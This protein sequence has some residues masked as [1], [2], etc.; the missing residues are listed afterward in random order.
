MNPA[1]SPVNFTDARAIPITASPR[2]ISWLVRYRPSCPPL[3]TMMARLAELLRSVVPAMVIL[4]SG[5]I[6]Y[7]AGLSSA[8]NRKGKTGP[9]TARL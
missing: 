8:R 1:A 4:C 3:P 9:R 6:V 2:P 7:R 5:E